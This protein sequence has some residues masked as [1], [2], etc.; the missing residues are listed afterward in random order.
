MGQTSSNQQTEAVEAV[1]QNGAL[2]VCPDDSACLARKLANDFGNLL[3]HY[4]EYYKL[5]HEDAHARASEPYPFE[6]AIGGPEDQVSWFDLYAMADKNP[7]QAQQRWEQIKKAAR[8]EL[9]TGF[10]ASRLLEDHEMMCWTRAKFLAIRSALREAWQPRDAQ[11]EHLIDQMAQYQTLVERW[12]QMLVAYTSL[13]NMGL[14]RRNNEGKHEMPR[15]SDVDAIREATGLIERFQK[16]YHLA[17][18]SLQNQ[19]Q[20][21]HAAVTVRTNQLNV[22]HG[23]QVNVSSLDAK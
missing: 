22:G 11:E 5:S 9:Q 16:L 4:Q 13:A 20:L 17:L 7:E 8:D 10:R 15:V 1:E 21:R 14:R 12:Q 18:R 23:L 2:P 3:K 6:R 19:S